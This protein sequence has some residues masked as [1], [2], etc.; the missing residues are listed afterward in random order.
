MDT[1]LRQVEAIKKIDRLKGL[2]FLDPKLREAAMLRLEHPDAT[3]AALGEMCDPPLKKS[4]INGRL[5][6]IEDIAS[7]I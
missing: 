1:S 6:K 5:R 3:I 7:K 4:G 2:K